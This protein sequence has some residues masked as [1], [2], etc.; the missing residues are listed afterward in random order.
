M[1]GAKK[2]SP[3]RHALLL[4]A[5]LFVLAIPFGYSVVSEYRAYAEY[6]RSTVRDRQEP[7]PWAEKHFTPA[8][9]VNASLDWIEG[10]PGMEDFCRGTLPHIVNEC[11]GSLD[12]R[13]WCVSNGDQ[14]K[15][16]S[17]GYKI[18]EARREAK[19][20]LER[21]RLFKQRCALALRALAEHCDALANQP[22]P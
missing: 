9:C 15:K 17:F 13:A 7:P 20:G 11:L 22:E 2:S 4:L 16:T 3:I 6:V 14:V 21:S 18:C 12:R 10:C 19:G 8:E 1:T 5:G